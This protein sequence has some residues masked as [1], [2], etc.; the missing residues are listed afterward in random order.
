M[1]QNGT[2]WHKLKRNNEYNNKI[3][4]FGD[5]LRHKT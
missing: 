2:K 4:I 5:N 3:F 1:Q